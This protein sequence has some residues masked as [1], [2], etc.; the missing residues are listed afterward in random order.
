LKAGGKALLV[1]LAF[2]GLEYLVHRQLEKDLDESIDK[3]RQGA[4]PWAQRLKREDP[5]KPVYMRVKIR[6]E[7]YQKFVP[8]LGW[9]PETPV[10]HMIGMAMVREEIDPPLVEVKDDPVGLFPPWRAGVTTT[11]TYTELMVP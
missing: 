1:A 7:D 6:S 11:V 5:S 8:L 2:A 9:M 4:M 3:T 10:L